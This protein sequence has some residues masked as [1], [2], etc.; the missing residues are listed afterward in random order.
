MRTVYIADDGKQ[1]D[2]EFDCNAYEFALRH[3]HLKDVH[4]FNKAGEE[5][6]DLAA[7]YTYN[8]SERIVVASEAAVNDLHALADYT[9]Y[10][11]YKHIN[12]VGEWRFD[13]DISEFVLMK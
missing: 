7:E 5:L 10:C 4:I 12:A 9:G 3:P 1:F 6:T 11:Y 2:D 13:D 8:N